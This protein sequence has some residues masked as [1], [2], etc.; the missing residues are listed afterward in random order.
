[1]IKNSSLFKNISLFFCLV[2]MLLLSLFCLVPEKDFQGVYAADEV[3][4]NYTYDSSNLYIPITRDSYAYLTDYLILRFSV[5]SSNNVTIT[6]DNHLFYNNGYNGS[7]HTAGNYLYEPNLPIVNHSDNSLV[8]GTSS[9]DY[10][11]TSHGYTYTFN[12]SRTSGFNANVKW[13]VIDSYIG[14]YEMGWNRIRLYSDS[15]NY[16]TMSFMSLNVGQNPNATTE[17]LLASR[18]YYL[19]SNFTDNENY[20]NGYNT[21]YNSGYNSGLSDGTSTGYNDGYTAGETVGY[22]NGYNDGLE[23]S[24]NYSFLSLIGAV[25]DAPVTAFTSLLNFNLLGFNMLG[26]VTGLLTLSLIIF[27]VKLILGGK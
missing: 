5:K 24:N 16:L 20:Q 27:I 7:G 8:V 11:F 23:Q 2:P 6:F 12:V 25:I 1:M 13:L 19:D 9:T 22:G 21:G 3:T 17:V 14:T 10:K 15:N 18:I 4:L 26:F